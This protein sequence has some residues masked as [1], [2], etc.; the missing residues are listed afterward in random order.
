MTART[1]IDTK[2]WRRRN[3]LVSIAVFKSFGFSYIHL[4]LPFVNEYCPL[5]KIDF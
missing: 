1:S 3:V 4:A 2:S 5:G